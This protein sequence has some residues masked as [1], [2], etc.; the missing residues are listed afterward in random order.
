MSRDARRHPAYSQSAPVG[1]RAEIASVG[2]LG[3]NRPLPLVPR[4]ARTSPR[5][6]PASP[7]MPCSFCSVRASSSSPVPFHIVSIL[8]GHKAHHIIP[9]V[10]ASNR[11][12]AR[13]ATS[14]CRR[15]P[16]T[17]YTPVRRRGYKIYAREKHPR[18]AAPGICFISAISISNLAQ[19]LRLILSLQSHTPAGASSFQ[20][21]VSSCNSQRS[22]LNLLPVCG[23]RAPSSLP[24]LRPAVCLPL[25][26][27]ACTPRMFTPRRQKLRPRCAGA[28][29]C[30]PLSHFGRRYE[31]RVL[32]RFSIPFCPACS[33]W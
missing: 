16:Q 1:T 29:R 28:L 30:A 21:P 17:A 6:Y 7:R 25:L 19:N 23:L 13:Y 15:L 14:S 33:C 11:R 27:L 26:F 32:L 24:P 2:I 10:Y 4:M 31:R 5:R 22:P 12:P 8:S 9:A 3:P 18:P 20:R